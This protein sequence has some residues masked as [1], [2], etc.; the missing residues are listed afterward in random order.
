MSVWVSYWILSLLRPTVTLEDDDSYGYQCRR[1]HLWSI[2]IQ[3]NHRKYL[4]VY[5]AHAIIQRF[6]VDMADILLKCIFNTDIFDFEGKL[7]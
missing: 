2:F 1:G 3:K 6:N 7:G 4:K 5:Q